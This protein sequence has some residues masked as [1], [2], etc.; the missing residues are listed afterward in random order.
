MVHFNSKISPITITK[1]SQQRSYPRFP[2]TFSFNFYNYRVTEQCKTRLKD[3]F[4]SY[5]IWPRHGQFEFNQYIKRI[6][7]NTKTRFH[8]F[9]RSI[10]LSIQVVRND[11]FLFNGNKSQ[12]LFSSQPLHLCVLSKKMLHLLISPIVSSVTP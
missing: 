12:K 1:P 6:M 8:S 4:L 3:P 9:Q 5:P 11:N 10:Q 2:I 7:Y